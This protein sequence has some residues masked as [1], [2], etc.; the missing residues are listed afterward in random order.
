MQVT[1]ILNTGRDRVE[2]R[3]ARLALHLAWFNCATYHEWP[4]SASGL[5]YNPRRRQIW[6]AA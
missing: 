4:E 1:S 6:F 5:T 3:A 2:Q